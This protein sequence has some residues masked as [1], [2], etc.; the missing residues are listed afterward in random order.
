MDCLVTWNFAHINNPFT[1]MMV[2]ALDGEQ[3]DVA[4]FT[5]AGLELLHPMIE[6][7]QE[8]NMPAA[9][10][11]SMFNAQGP[12]AVPSNRLASRLASRRMLFL[13]ALI[14][15]PVLLACTRNIG[16]QS[17]GW[18]PPVSE[19]RVVYIGDSMSFVDRV[20]TITEVVGKK[21]RVRFDDQRPESR[22]SI[23]GTTTLVLEKEAN[24]CADCVNQQKFSTKCF[25]RSR[26]YEPVRCPNFERR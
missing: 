26:V 3:L 11:A 12:N 9:H 14:M 24:K 22:G 8:P 18:N 13:F 2:A 17:D 5:K 21:V 20:G 1:K 23:F 19:D 10:M 15:L 4:R 25:F 7:E 16:D 6:L